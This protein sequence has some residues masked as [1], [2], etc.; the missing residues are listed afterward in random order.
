MTHYIEL[1]QQ[2]S[3]CNTVSHFDIPASMGE[4]STLCAHESLSIRP[5]VLDPHIRVSIDHGLHGIL[6]L[7]SSAVKDKTGPEL[8]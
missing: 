2:C 1:L 5:S 8:E 6:L 4:S 3:P 7:Q